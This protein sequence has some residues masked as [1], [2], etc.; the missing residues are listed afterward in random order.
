[1]HSPHPPQ[2]VDRGMPVGA[3]R[4]GGRVHPSENNLGKAI[5]VEPWGRDRWEASG[6]GGS[7]E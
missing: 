4:A 6:F 3:R 7:F 5:V 2:H 1:M